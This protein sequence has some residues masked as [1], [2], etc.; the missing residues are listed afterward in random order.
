MFMPL[1]WLSDRHGIGVWG[2]VCTAQTCCVFSPDPALSS[3]SIGLIDQALWLQIGSVQ[4][5]PVLKQCLT[6]QA[7]E[8]LA[9][10]LGSLFP[11]HTP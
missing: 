6:A 5:S 10:P 1:T 2:I 9:M 3:L 4:S 8:I 7:L 11:S